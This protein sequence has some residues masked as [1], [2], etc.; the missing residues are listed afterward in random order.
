MTDFRFEDENAIQFTAVGQES[1]VYGYSPKPGENGNW[2]IYDNFGG[3]QDSGIKVGVD[4]DVE[5][6]EGGHRVTTISSE[7]VKTFDVMDGQSGSGAVTS[8]NGE[9]GDV[10]IDIPDVSGLQEKL[11]PG[12]NIT[13]E[14]NVISSEG[15]AV[16]GIVQITDNPGANNQMYFPTSEAQEIEI[17]TMADISDV[18]A[19]LSRIESELVGVSEAASALAESAAELNGVVG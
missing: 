3:W 17:P 2:Y 5:D 12:A 10:T 11:I 15:G 9:T 6:I 1:P 7:G 8:V 14:G 19:D 4:I 18:K 16:D 13:I